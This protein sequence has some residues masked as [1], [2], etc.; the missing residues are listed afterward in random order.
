MKST[1]LRAGAA[2]LATTA[3]LVL[4]G[5]AGGTEDEQPTATA[6]A[7]AE[8]QAE[9]TEE[10]AT[11]EVPDV[12]VLILETAQGNLARNGLEVEVVDESGAPLTVDDA[13]A[14]TVTAQEP[15]EGTVD[16]GSVVTLTVAPR[17]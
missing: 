6:T 16:R 1:V 8:E 13:T 10:S 15:A 2:A 7:E 9:E 4:A 17:G 3:V 5:C 12:T 14:Y 11:V